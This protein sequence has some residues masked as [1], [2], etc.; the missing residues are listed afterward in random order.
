M[1][2]WGKPSDSSVEEKIPGAYPAW[3]YKIPGHVGTLPCLQRVK[4]EDKLPTDEQYEQ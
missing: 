1:R 2:G 4:S 3:V